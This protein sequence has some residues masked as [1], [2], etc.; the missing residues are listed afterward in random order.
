MR[1]SVQRFLRLRPFP[2][3][4]P[5]GVASLCSMASAV[6]RANPTS[7]PFPAQDY[8]IQPFLSRRAR[9][10]PARWRSPSFRAVDFPA[11][12]G[13]STARDRHRACDWHPVP[14]CLPLRLTAS[15]SRTPDFAVL[16]LTCRFPLSTLRWHPHECPRMTRGR[17]DSPF[18]FRIELSSTIYCQLA[19]ALSVRSSPS[20]CC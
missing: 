10:A 3:P 18:L 15:A 4:S 20:G 12:A 9:V 19:G 11:C 1:E 5:P 6:L 14:C 2:P 17:N 16:Y 8:G 13:S 7:P